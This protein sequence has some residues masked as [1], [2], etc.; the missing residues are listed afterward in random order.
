MVIGF[1]AKRAF[2]NRSGLGSYSR[3]L[4]NSFFRFYPE[5]KYLLYSPH[6]KN[7]IDFTDQEN[8]MLRTPEKTMHKIFPS[9]WRTRGI[10][11]QIIDDN[12]DVYHGLSSELPVSLEKSGI[13]TLVTVH[14]LIYMRYPGLYKAID[15][16][17]YFGKIKHACKNSDHIIA[18]SEQTK[19]DIV[20]FTGI[21][22]K[23]ISVIYQDCH[24]SFYK[25][26]DEEMKK[27]LQKKYS[28]QDEYLLYVGT[29]E[30]RKNLLS[31][32]R[33]LEINRLDIQLVAV[34]KKTPYYN[35]VI[36]YIRRSN[37][38]NF[39]VLDTMNN[40]D[41][42]AIYRMAS[43]FIYPSVFEGFGIPIIEALVSEVPVITSKGSCFREAG[44]PGSLYIDPYNPGELAE[45]ITSIL[46]DKSLSDLMVKT[47]REYAK[48]F[49]AE[50]I[51]EQY[52]NLYSKIIQ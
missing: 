51:A 6:G 46:S 39:T 11:T 47:G 37:I 7:K 28:L 38:K 36:S 29:I 45:A 32:I 42:P 4:L 41:L 9:L 8:Y 34:G 31:I 49:R 26:P 35:K 43:C 23:K 1:D 10:I 40:E 33:A 14:D 21:D 52:M 30:E 48:K 19:D 2:F 12:P 22:S 44:G 50:L 20:K 15:R 3:N 16:N 24:P 17:I 18:I 5:N 27:K 25:V 13:K